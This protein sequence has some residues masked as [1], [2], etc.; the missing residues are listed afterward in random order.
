MREVWFGRWLPLLFAVTTAVG[1]WL[2][3]GPLA[4]ST[5]IA[6][7]VVRRLRG[8]MSTALGRTNDVE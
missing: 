4:Q 1:G 3:L 8:T 7:A 2:M 5:L 6:T